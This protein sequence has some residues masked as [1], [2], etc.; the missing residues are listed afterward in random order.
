MFRVGEGELSISGLRMKD[1]QKI[2][3]TC[4]F[5]SS[6]VLPIAQDV[7]TL[8][9]T[10]IFSHF[11]SSFHPFLNCYELNTD[12]HLLDHGLVIESLLMGL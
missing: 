10:L 2:N 12:L 1:I 9:V 7:V 5:Y 4:S 6:Q 3:Q 11:H 8:E